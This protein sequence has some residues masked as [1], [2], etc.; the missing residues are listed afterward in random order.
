[1]QQTHFL[2]H[3]VVAVALVVQAQVLQ[4]QMAETAEQ[5]RLQASLE[6]ALLMLVVVVE[7]PLEIILL[8]LEAQEAVEMEGTP[9]PALLRLLLVRKIQEVV[10][11]AKLAVLQVLAAA[12]AS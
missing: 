5:A 12:Q 1:V 3:V 11:A 9:L 6:A 10:G 4:T 2:M 7:A 8:E